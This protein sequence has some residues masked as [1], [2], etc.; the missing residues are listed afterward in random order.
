ETGI[1]IPLEQQKEAPFEPIDPDKFSRDLAN[2]I[3]TLI[4]NKPLRDTMAKNGRKRVEDYFDWTA[5]AKQVETLYKSL[6]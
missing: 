5:I 2:G 4:N 3:N 6:I 1:L